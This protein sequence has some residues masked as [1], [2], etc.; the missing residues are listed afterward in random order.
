MGTRRFRFGWMDSVAARLLVPGLALAVLLSVVFFAQR[1][2]TATLSGNVLAQARAEQQVSRAYQSETLL[3]DLE[4][5]VRGFLLTHDRAFL[6]PWQSARRTF[7]VSSSV[8]VRLE[9]HSGSVAMGLARRIR[10][11]G[12]AYINDFAVPDI[13][14]VEA[15]PAIATSLAAALDGKRRV[16]ALRPLF[17]DLITLNQRPA[18]PAEQRAQAAASRSSAYELAGLA[19][20]LVLIT[21]SAVYLRRGVLGPIR[22][23]GNVAD[24]RAAGDMS[25]R[26]APS[27]TLELS[28]LGR[29]FNTMADALQDSHDRLEEQTVEL[30]RSEVFL[31]SVLEHVP[32]LLWVKDARELRF[33]RLNRAAEETLGRPR[34]EV[35]GHNAHE[36]FAADEAA[37]IAAQDDATLAG[38][39]PLEIPEDRLQTR[40]HG[41]LYMHTTK[42]PVMDENGKPQYLL[43]ISKDITERKR[44]EQVVGKAREEAERA[45]RA[46][47]EFLSRMSHELRT[48][49]N[50][51][52][53]F[54]QLLEMDGLS[55]AQR[56]PVHYILES[57]SH[58]LGLINEVLDI[59]RIEAGRLT[60]HPEPV[61]VRVLL[62][63]VVSMLA[64][65]AAGRRVVVEAV[66]M[67]AEYCVLADPQRLKQVLLNL[68]SNAIKYNREGGNVTIV[69]EPSESRLRILVRDTGH[70]ITAQ[71]I[72]QAFEPFERLGAELGDVEGTGLGLTL[73][74]QLMEGMG[75]TLTVQSEPGVG[76]TFTAEL[77]LAAVD[78]RLA[79]IEN[80]VESNDYVEPVTG[81]PVELLYVEDNV[82]NI[83]LVERILERRP[84]ITVNA[85]GQGRLGVELARHHLPDVI[86]LDLHLPDMTGEQVLHELRGDPLTEQIPVIILTADA[87]PDQAIRLHDLGADAYLTKP[88]EVSSFLA[89]VDEL[90][91]D[92]AMVS[93]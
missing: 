37:V 30:R 91:G 59:S 77:E 52:L 44:A 24:A 21:I 14:S 48:P 4:T 20:A 10:S 31:E 33:V 49:L 86:V 67:A 58:L 26:V 73:A 72:S 12:E 34:A 93:A 80:P 41:L 15:D 55:D 23:V 90:V 82:A 54:G 50:S 27:S 70:G 36:L 92:R 46:K 38:G 85:A 17:T 7:P 68:G 62:G 28:R 84:G 57:G 53:G 69:C 51:I 65:I 9:V 8:L 71:R 76:S 18:A 83:K 6:A 47:S 42:V 32:A 56:E 16:D 74:R 3:L 25:V 79:A 66:P 11:G 88:V 2:A 63:E 89:T 75:G 35:I 1:D 61:L 64:P 45:N 60:I 22:R 13:L 43:G 19:A 40:D 87:S 81:S 78:V 39:V 5:G 29:S